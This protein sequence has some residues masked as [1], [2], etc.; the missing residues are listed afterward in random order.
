[1]KYEQHI[2]EYTILGIGRTFEWFTSV[3]M[4]KYMG[5]RMS[6]IIAVVRNGTFYHFEPT[7]ERQIIAE[8][9]LHKVAKGQVNF[10]KEFTVFAKNRKAWE[11]FIQQPEKSFS[12]NTL[13]Q[14]FVYYNDM[15]GPAYA[16]VDTMDFI[17]ALPKSK[18]KEFIAWVQKTRKLAEPV[19]KRSE[20]EFI[21]RYLKWF[22]KHNKLSH[23]AKE[24]EYVHVM[25]K[26]RG[27]VTDEGG[28][29]SHAAIVAR[30]LKKPCVI[31]TEYAT[32]VFR[33]GDMVEVDATKGIVRKL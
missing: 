1:M 11:K 33:D 23:T 25:K 14:L 7:G 29:L 17:E 16:A 32:K 30:E 28:V 27:F 22:V 6:E 21:P 4:Q 18:H 2:R 13:K 5:K 15:I 24:L 8:A 20:M 9:F 3:E 12:N 31:G 26:V 10:Q 19:Y